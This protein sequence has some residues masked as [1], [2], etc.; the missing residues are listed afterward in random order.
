MSF[1]ISKNTHSNF[2]L[3]MYEY[4]CCIQYFDLL[5]IKYEYFCILTLELL[6]LKYYTLG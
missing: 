5:V 6:Y 4:K 1:L 3:K 2:Y